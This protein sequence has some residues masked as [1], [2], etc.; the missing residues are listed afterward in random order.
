ML[1]KNADAPRIDLRLAGNL[2]VSVYD[3][4]GRLVKNIFQ[5]PISTG[6]ATVRWNGTDDDGHD[7]SSGVYLCRFRM[8]G[9]TDTRKMVPAT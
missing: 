1:E 7:L 4:S 9:F 8:N 2:D 3:L 6:I 5:G